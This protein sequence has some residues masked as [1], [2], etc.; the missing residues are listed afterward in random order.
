MHT[1][2]SQTLKSGHDFNAIQTERFPLMV[3]STS[4]EQGRAPV[5]VSKWALRMSE[6]R[7][8]CDERT[9]EEISQFAGIALTSWESR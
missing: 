5:K 9:D 4:S 1:Q 2:K 8:A 6:I 7:N 3:L